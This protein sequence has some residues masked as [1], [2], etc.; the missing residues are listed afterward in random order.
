MNSDFTWEIHPDQAQI[1][2]YDD[3]H[4]GFSDAD[5]GKFPSHPHNQSYMEG[6]LESL[7]MEAGYKNQF[8]TCKDPFYME[9]YNNAQHERGC[10]TPSVPDIREKTQ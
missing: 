7:G 6:W 2:G 10:H 9:G 8:P 3:W 5:S 4:C 1:L